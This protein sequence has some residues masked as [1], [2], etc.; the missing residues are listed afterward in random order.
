MLD[1][2]DGPPP[3][4]LK[5]VKGVA[6]TL[7]YLQCSIRAQVHREGLKE[8]TTPHP[9]GRGEALSAIVDRGGSGYDER[10]DYSSKPG[11]HVPMC[12]WQVLVSEDL[13]GRSRLWR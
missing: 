7:T 11:R 4:C 5:Q 2:G 10:G 1:V 8:I 9:V 3:G 6:W 12:P 13:A